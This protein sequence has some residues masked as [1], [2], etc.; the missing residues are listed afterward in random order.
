MQKDN[1]LFI[2][3]KAPA[4]LS[5][6]A[7]DLAETMDDYYADFYGESQDRIQE[8]RRQALHSYGLMRTK[9]DTL[10]KLLNEQLGTTI[11]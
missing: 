2:F 10:K 6:W 3:K 1:A 8:T 11:Q 5:R 9:M 7:T 4:D